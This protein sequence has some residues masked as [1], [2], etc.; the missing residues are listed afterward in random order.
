MREP[1]R[2]RAPARLGARLSLRS[3]DRD[4]RSRGGFS[5]EEQKGGHAIDD[6]DVAT[7][8]GKA[9]TGDKK[10]DKKAK[11]DKEDPNPDKNAPVGLRKDQVLIQFCMS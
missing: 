4:S 2:P 9:A 7:V 1:R 11:K 10:T 3:P 5:G 6:S 8:D